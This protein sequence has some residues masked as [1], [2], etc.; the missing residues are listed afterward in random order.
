MEDIIFLRDKSLSLE[1]IDDFRTILSRQREVVL[2]LFGR[3][4][5]SPDSEEEGEVKVSYQKNE[6]QEKLADIILS[7]LYNGN[8]FSDIKLDAALILAAFTRFVVDSRSDDLQTRIAEELIAA[9]RSASEKD[10][11]CDKEKLL[12][13]LL[14]MKE[15]N[16]TPQLIAW[17]GKVLD[18]VKQLNLE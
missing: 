2:T 8:D 6:I 3:E 10:L 9:L 15:S 18:S 7:F 14:A 17:L 4:G 1:T 12:D 5:S 16:L 13:L 11:L